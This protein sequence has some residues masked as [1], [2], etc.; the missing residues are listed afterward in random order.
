MTRWCFVLGLVAGCSFALGG[1]D[2]RRPPNQAPSCDTGK[3]AVVLDGVMATSA[4]VTTLAVGS[5][6]GA[7]ALV[8]AVIGAVFVG[9]AI[10]GNNVVNACRAA[11]AEY[12]ATLD[13][14]PPIADDN[15]EP[16]PARFAPPG[17]GLAPPA[18]ALT[19]APGR[20]GAPGTPGTPGTGPVMAPATAPATVATGSAPAAGSVPPAPAASAPPPSSTDPWAAFWKEVQ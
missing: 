3:T 15:R 17:A 14:Q 1:P 18:P 6:S 5:V 16:M 12:L 13:A 9:A 10:H 7:A 4:G 2:P 11:N 19:M 8:P 20:P